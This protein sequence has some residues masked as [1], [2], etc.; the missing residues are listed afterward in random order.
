MGQ[1]KESRG[2]G[3][4]SGAGL[5]RVPNL[6]LGVDN[7]PLPTKCQPLQPRHYRLTGICACS[8]MLLQT[9]WCHGP[10]GPVAACAAK[11]KPDAGPYA[12]SPCKFEPR[13]FLQVQSELSGSERRSMPCSGSAKPCSNAGL[14]QAAYMP[15]HL[16]PG[17]LFALPTTQS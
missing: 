15:V 14:K 12:L 13:L 5:A 3:K 2:S 17:Q 7:R 4:V 8:Q 9:S 1:P 11:D 16:P 6:S 10:S